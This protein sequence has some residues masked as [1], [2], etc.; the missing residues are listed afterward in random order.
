MAKYTF[1]Q[2]EKKYGSF[3]DGAGKIDIE[4]FS[5]AD[6][7]TVRSIT[8]QISA[9][10][11]AGYAEFTIFDGFDE[12]SDG[13]SMD[14]T[15]AKKLAEGKKVEISLGYGEKL[16]NVFSGYIDGIRVDYSYETAFSITVICL[17]GK[18]MMMNSFRS[19]IKTN[20]KKYS[21]AVKKTLNAYSG[22]FSV[23]KV[24]PTNELE[25][26]F[27]QLNESD[28]DFVVRLAKRLNYS[29][30]IHLGKAYFV[31]FG[32][33][34]TVIFEI[35]PKIRLTEFSIETSLR[36]RVS[37]VIVVNNDEKDEKKRIKSEV[38]SV[39]VLES[40]SS[41]K[42][43]A[44]R[45]ITSDMVKTI[46]DPAATTAEIAKNIAQAEIDRMSYSSVEGTVETVGLPE[47]YPGVFAAVSGFGSAFEKDYYIKKVTHRLYGEKFTTTL[48][49][50]GNE[51]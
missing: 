22:C 8:V 35:T 13:F 1:D 6:K 25:I 14:K 28:Y 19:E 3:S 37:K 46:T 18:G 23:G 33:D 38:S 36:K 16:T 43:A 7:F 47:L 17:D 27:S 51:I 9:L 15:L 10:Y 12:S 24:T 45:A 49:L 42:A 40:G 32:N 48:E 44:N 39:N 5:V 11:E 29:F 50:G 2:L 34:R 20:V 30:Y 31:P 21:D 41:S 4:G 26:P